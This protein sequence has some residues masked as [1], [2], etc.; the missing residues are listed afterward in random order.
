[1]SFSPTTLPSSKLYT[2]THPIQSS[3]TDIYLSSVK[4]VSDET[5]V[6][7][8]STPGGVILRDMG[9]H[10]YVSHTNRDG[11]PVSTVLRKIQLVPQ[12]N[13]RKA[14][15]ENDYYTGYIPMGV[16]TYDLVGN[17]CGVVRLN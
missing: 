14:T 9:K 10:V 5:I 3:I 4:W 8:L 11:E 17:P 2:N 1:M 7:G 12:G 6:G 16:Q 15:A 13:Q